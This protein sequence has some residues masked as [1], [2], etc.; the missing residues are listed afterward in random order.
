MTA[1]GTLNLA[2]IGGV[3]LLV[4]I[5]WVLLGDRDRRDDRI[6]RTPVEPNDEEIDRTD[7]R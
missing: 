7:R 2:L 1:D 5:L 4:I 3:V 6:G